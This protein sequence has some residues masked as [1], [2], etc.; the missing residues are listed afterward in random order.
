MQKL[1]TFIYYSKKCYELVGR[2]RKTLETTPVF[3]NQVRPV[4]APKHGKRLALPGGSLN[5]KPKRVKNETDIE[6]SK[7][8]IKYPPYNYGLEGE[9]KSSR[10]NTSKEKCAEVKGEVLFGVFPVKLALEAGRRKP[11]RLFLKERGLTDSLRETLTL[12]D[13]LG[14]EKEFV[15]KEM[16]DKLSGDRPHQGICL[17][18]SHLYANNLDSET[19]MRS[20]DLIEE[21]GLPK[22]WLLT[23]RIK[24]PMNFGAILRSAFYLGVDKVLFPKRYSCALSP[25]VSK[26]SAGALEV[27]DLA[28]IS[29][30]T[31]LMEV[32]ERW[33]K[34]GGQVLGTTCDNSS[35][36]SQ[37]LIGCSVDVPT[38]IIVG[39][40]REGLDKDVI[41]SCD[42]LLYINPI[43]SVHA[44]GPVIDSLNVSVATGIVLYSVMQNRQKYS[45]TPSCQ[46]EWLLDVAHTQYS[47]HDKPRESA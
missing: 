43:G 4:Y 27:M 35:D 40:E 13:K 9:G 33:K 10:K 41:K 1:D 11:H 37:Q 30:D 21:N 7:T 22:V 44:S 29:T 5:K 32:L 38:I 17:D 23:Y 25:V 6:Q 46:P 12:A 28:C 15:S 24:D 14:I 8:R 3:V 39:N 20:E 47:S 2:C 16:L 42:K 34:A 36:K 26:A 31:T 18:A 19:Q 45:R